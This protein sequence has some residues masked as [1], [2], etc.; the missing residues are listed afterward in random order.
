MIYLGLIVIVTLL[1]FVFVFQSR[2]NHMSGSTLI[3]HMISF[4]ARTRGRIAN[5]ADRYETQADQNYEPIP[6]WALCVMW[7]NSRLLVTAG[8][9]MLDAA[10]RGSQT[11]NNCIQDTMIATHAKLGRLLVHTLGEKGL[12]AATHANRGFYGAA[13]AA[14]YRDQVLYGQG[15]T[16][17]VSAPEFGFLENHV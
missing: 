7:L 16:E 12:G 9:K 15:L 6:T 3:Q 1:S 5:L 17:M 2:L 13:A 4:S 8:K 11:A 14:C 10:S